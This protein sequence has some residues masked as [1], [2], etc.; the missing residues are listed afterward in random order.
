[1]SAN[2][3]P[4]ISHRV[5]LS[6]EL[7]L[8]RAQKRHRARVHEAQETLRA[9][10]QGLASLLHCHDLRQIEPNI[11]ALDL[12]ATSQRAT[13]SLRDLDGTEQPHHTPHWRAPL[14]W[15]LSSLGSCAA[16]IA[17]RV[18]AG[19]A[20]LWGLLGFLAVCGLAVPAE[21]Y[22]HDSAPAP[23]HAPSRALPLLCVLSALLLGE[24]LGTLAAWVEGNHKLAH[25][26]FQG[27][28]AALALGL[29]VALHMYG[30]W[31]RMN[32]RHN[33]LLVL[34]AVEEVRAA[35]LHLRRLE[36]QAP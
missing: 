7:A 1:M 18:G 16:L 14:F 2:L 15:G 5:A 35:R 29:P 27:I 30:R 4:S 32:H 25:A 24:S 33:K 8:H 23:V 36:D 19:D 3:P 34:R 12:E 22:G 28:P 6:D 10:E 13:P 31:Q 21:H 17:A 20:W 9:R 26:L 11:Y